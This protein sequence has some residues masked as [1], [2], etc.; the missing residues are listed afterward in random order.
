[1]LTPHGGLNVGRL[2]FDPS[3]TAASA[4]NLGIVTAAGGDINVIARDNVD[5]NQSRI[6][7]VGKGDMLLWSSFGDIDAGRGGKTVTGAPEP[8][9]IVENGKVVVDTSG[10]FAGS[11][12][13]ALDENSFLGLY[14]PRGAIDAGEAGIRSA[15]TL[16]INAQVIRNGNDIQIKGGGTLAPPPVVGNAA[17]N[18]G[19]LGQSATSAGAE[20]VTDSEGRG[21][22]AKRQLMLELLGFGERE[23][24]ADEEDEDDKKKGESK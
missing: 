3:E 20:S 12:I 7:T 18:I 22:T 23:P 19:A 17:T 24:G 21:Q 16:S 6:F 15:G 10:S 11:G 4:G 9:Y 13:A 14:A 1:M 5:V 2:T 8:K